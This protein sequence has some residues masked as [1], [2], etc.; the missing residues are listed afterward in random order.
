[1]RLLAKHLVLHIKVDV[2]AKDQDQNNALHYA[3]CCGRQE[4]MEF[5]LT[6]DLLQQLEHKNHVGRTIL[7]WAAIKGHKPMAKWLRKKFPQVM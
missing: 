4:I 7:T 3:A 5:L 6:T 1:M 2:L